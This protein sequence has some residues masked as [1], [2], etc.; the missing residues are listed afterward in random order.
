[1][2]PIGLLFIPQVIYKHGEQWWNDFNRG[3]LICPPA[4]SSNPTSSHLVTNYDE[5]GKENDEFG[6]TKYFVHTSK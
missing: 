2:A 3:K 1:V 6:L 4:V 5:L